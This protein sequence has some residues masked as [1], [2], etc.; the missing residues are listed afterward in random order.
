[1]STSK[2]SP[3]KTCP[4]KNKYNIDGSNWPK[5]TTNLN[6]PIKP[7]TISNNSWSNKEKNYNKKIDQSSVNLNWSI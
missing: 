6:S 4:S 3:R 7:T 2:P 5:L 1:M